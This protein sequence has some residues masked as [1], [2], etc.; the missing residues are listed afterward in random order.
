MS[1]NN[2]FLLTAR[3]GKLMTFLWIFW[4]SELLTHSCFFALRAFRAEAK[5]W[6]NYAKSTFEYDQK[7]IATWTASPGISLIYDLI[8]TWRVSLAG[9]GVGVREAVIRSYYL[10][11]IIIKTLQHRGHIIKIILTHL[12]LHVLRCSS[13]VLNVFHYTFLLRIRGTT[14]H[15]KKKYGLN[16]QWPCPKELIA[17]TFMMT[18]GDKN[19]LKCLFIY[20]VVSVFSKLCQPLLLLSAFFLSRMKNVSFFPF[21]RK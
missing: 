20:F 6:T 11:V 21:L 4:I 7:Y 16:D 5:S 13:P 12:K 15:V 1:K 18:S 3:E 2:C 14:D 17:M 10:N 9:C 8:F 19:G